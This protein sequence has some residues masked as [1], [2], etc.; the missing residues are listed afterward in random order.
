MF[1]R[2]QQFRTT[3][4]SAGSSRSVD[5][6]RGYTLMEVLVVMMII[7]ILLALLVPAL[8]RL[9][10]ASKGVATRTTINQIDSIIQ[11]RYDA[12]LEA[13]VSV[14]AK[15]LAAL[16]S[17]VD[18]KE[19]EFL[20][21]KLMYRQ[22][23][24]Q[25][26]RDLYGLDYTRNTN[27]DAP[28]LDDWETESGKNEATMEPAPASMD[29]DDYLNA[30]EFF[31]F[32]MMKGSSVRVLPGGK[33]YPMPVLEMD[34]INQAHL[35]DSDGN[36]LDELIDDWGQPLRFYNFPTHLFRDDGDTG[37]LPTRNNASILI[38]GLPNDMSANGPLDR[39]PLDP[40][41]LLA[42]QF[43]SSD[44]NFK[45]GPGGGDTL[46]RVAMNTI[47]YHIPGTYY[48][49]LLVSAGPDGVLGLG[50]PISTDTSTGPPQTAER[51]AKVLSGTGAADIRDN[52][53]NRNTQQ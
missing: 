53:T 36:G 10:G 18:E 41:G 48:V 31:L 47:N 12:V 16:N 17:G 7:G 25:R 23:L 11:A 51:L 22:A 39:D 35:Q 24:P 30:S 15:K 26:I 49:P 50:E 1:N 46:N 21:R 8:G 37:N 5:S 43:S 40:S 19:A 45:Y 27:D 34:N 9:L 20:I 52:I 29:A 38:S 14:E 4:N 2:Q 42:S 32:A 6:L 28:Y 33:S 3:R 44:S 13:D